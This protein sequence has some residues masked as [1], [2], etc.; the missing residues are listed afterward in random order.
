MLLPNDGTWLL[1]FLFF[2]RGTC[3]DIVFREGG[4]S[5]LY[6]ETSVSEI[7]GFPSPRK[8]LAT[9]KLT[10]ERLRYNGYMQ[11]SN[12]GHMDRR[13]V[14]TPKPINSPINL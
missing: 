1:L 11:I 5:D 13:V 8:K 10:T 6:D 9:S 4:G 14:M 7:P 12:D 2:F 3:F